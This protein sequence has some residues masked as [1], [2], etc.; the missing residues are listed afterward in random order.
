MREGEQP[1][2][3]REVQRCLVGVE[4]RCTHSKTKRAD[5]QDKRSTRHCRP[6]EAHERVLTA[7]LGHR[8]TFLWYVVVGVGCGGFFDIP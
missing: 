7:V 5:E 6:E 1:A 8:Q 4:L 3:E 2:E